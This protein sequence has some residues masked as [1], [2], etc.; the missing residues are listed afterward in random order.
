M[1]DSQQ[2]TLTLNT[3]ANPIITDELNKFFF[4]GLVGYQ[5]RDDISAYVSYNELKDNAN[6]FYRDKVHLFTTGALYK[7]IDSIVFKVQYIHAY[8][9]N[10]GPIIIKYT[11]KFFMGGI[12]V[13]F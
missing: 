5:I 13:L 7:P 10:D 11:G 1:S 4:Y 6:L 8:L 12:S 3:Q 9:Q 2:E